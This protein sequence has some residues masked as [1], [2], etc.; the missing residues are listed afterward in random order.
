MATFTQYLNACIEKLF[1][2][3]LIKSKSFTIGGL[4][5]VCLIIV[6]LNWVIFFRKCWKATWL[7]ISQNTSFLTSIFQN[8][9]AL[10]TTM[11]RA[12]YIYFN[13]NSLK[14]SASSQ[15]LPPNKALELKFPIPLCGSI[16]QT[17][18]LCN[19]PLLSGGAI[20]M[21]PFPIHISFEVELSDKKRR[22][23]NENC[24]AQ[25]W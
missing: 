25:R 6:R 12:P 23:S 13:V 2:P 11:P 8:E 4:A 24:I 14:S 15:R 17:Y 1:H 22:N 20:W 3:I 19:W 9:C 10:F 21:L 16:N 7:S 5:S 18:S